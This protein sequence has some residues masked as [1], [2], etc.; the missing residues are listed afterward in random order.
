M[1]F[2][3]VPHTLLEKGFSDR[4]KQREIVRETDSETSKKKQDKE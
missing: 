4:Q 1:S 3:S 2:W